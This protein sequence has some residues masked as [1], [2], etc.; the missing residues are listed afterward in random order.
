MLGKID[1]IA[2]GTRDSSTQCAWQNTGFLRAYAINEI[3][4]IK[5]GNSS[6]YTKRWKSSSEVTLAKK[7]VTKRENTKVLLC[8]LDN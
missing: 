6:G 5:Q 7:R 2:R 4:S 3:K 1:L 8:P